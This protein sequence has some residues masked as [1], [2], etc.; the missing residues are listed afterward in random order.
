MYSYCTRYCRHESNSYDRLLQQN[1]M[2]PLICCLSDADATSLLYYSFISLNLNSRKCAI[3]F[4]L[5][6]SL[7]PLIS[8]LK[9]KEEKILPLSRGGKKKKKKKITETPCTYSENAHNPFLYFH[10]KIQAL[11]T[12]KLYVRHS[13][14]LFPIQGNKDKYLVS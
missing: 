14:S 2:I 4:L 13:F 9:G 10:N 1:E 8:N 3:I 5:L 6:S 11:E 7:L 12:L